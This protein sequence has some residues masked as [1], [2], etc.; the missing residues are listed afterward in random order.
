MVL[1][2]TPIFKALIV[3]FFLLFL[4]MMLM[5]PV[6]TW[7]PPNMQKDFI[8]EYYHDKVLMEALFTNHAPLW[9]MIFCLSL[10]A[11]AFGLFKS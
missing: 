10:I 11:V 5:I 2:R 1:P 4:F 8:P 3:V 6:N 9:V 7:V